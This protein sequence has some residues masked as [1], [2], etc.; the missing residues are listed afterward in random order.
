MIIYTMVVVIPELLDQR[1]GGRGI[2]GEMQWIFP[3]FSL[4][5]ATV[6]VS[7]TTTRINM[8]DAVQKNGGRLLKSI[9]FPLIQ[10]THT[11]HIYSRACTHIIHVCVSHTHT[12]T[13]AQVLIRQ[14]IFQNYTARGVLLFF[15]F[16]C[17]RHNLVHLT[18][19][20]HS[21]LFCLF[22]TRKKISKKSDYRPLN[23]S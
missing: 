20:C 2:E 17:L 8:L 15:F 6:T 18:F 4:C 19:P 7:F 21:A 16:F 12:Q 3:L 10:N 14:V 11:A 5:P 9:I 1:L 23:S 13:R 22:Q